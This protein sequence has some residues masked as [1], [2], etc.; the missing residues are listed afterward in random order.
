MRADVEKTR[1]FSG[2]LRTV[3]QKDAKP[4]RMNREETVFPTDLIESS[5]D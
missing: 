5:F 3:N 4:R 1:A 2:F